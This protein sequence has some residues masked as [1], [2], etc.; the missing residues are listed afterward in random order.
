MEAKAAFVG[1]E[2]AAETQAVPAV[3]LDLLPIVLPGDAKDYLPFGFGQAF[4]DR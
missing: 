4:Q 3:D 2:S 1:A